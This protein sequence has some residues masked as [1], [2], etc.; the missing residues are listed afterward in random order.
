[1]QSIIAVAAVI[2]GFVLYFNFFEIQTL[3][4]VPSDLVF[5][6]L[7]ALLA[8]GF[9]SLMSGLFLVYEWLESR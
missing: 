5:Y 9:I 7:S 2:F 3:L 1:M 4:N 8:I 6:Y